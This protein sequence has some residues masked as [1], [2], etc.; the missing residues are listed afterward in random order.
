VLSRKKEEELII[1]DNI[2]VKVLEIC[3]D[4]VRLGLTAPDSVIISRSE[5]IAASKEKKHGME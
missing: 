1:G 2:R 3:G 4:R 5:L